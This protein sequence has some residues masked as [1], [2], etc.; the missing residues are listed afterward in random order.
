MAILVT[1]GAGYIGSHIVK[2][3]LDREEEVIVL[4]NLSLGHEDAVLGGKLLVGDLRDKEFLDKTFSENEIE[5]VIHFAANSLVGESMNNP[6]KYYENNVYGT[7]CLLEKMME[8]NVDKIVF[9]STAAVYGVPEHIPIEEDNL[10][11]PTNVYGETKLVMERM[12][13]WFSKIYNLNYVSLR[14]FNACGADLSGKIGERHNPETHLI[15]NVLKAIKN[16]DYVNLFGD[17]YPTEDGTCIRD[18]IHVTDLAD[19]HIKAYNFLRENKE[20]RIF[21]LGSES[22]FSVKEVIDMAGKV[23]EKEVKVKISER[24]PGD[25]PVLIASSKKIRQELGWEAKHSNME[26][27]ISSAWNFMNSRG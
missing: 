27:I 26:T 24:R 25:P 16:D 22:G 2:E 14:Y 15:P 17:D 8:Y 21:N 11:N 12:F 6:Y 20:N 9:S 5:G 4:D 19:A 10:T 3:L 1:G 7:L 13:D 18:Y 23:L